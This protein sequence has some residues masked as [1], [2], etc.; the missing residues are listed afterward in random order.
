MPSVRAWDVEMAEREDS[1]VEMPSVG[2]G[3]EMPSV[4]AWH[5]EAQRRG[6]GV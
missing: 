1:G 2:L 3:G 4:R 5:V 6:L